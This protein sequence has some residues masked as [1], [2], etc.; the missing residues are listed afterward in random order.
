MIDSDNTSLWKML[1]DIASNMKAHRLADVFRSISFT[2]REIYGPH[3]H[4]RIEINYVKKGRCILHLDN[5]SINFKEGEM[6]I[7][8]SNVNHKFEAGQKGTTLLQLEFL[9]DI[10]ND[11]HFQTE[12]AIPVSLFTTNN[13]VLKI[14]NNIRIMRTVQRI[15][16]ELNVKKPRYE[17]LVVMYYAEL[18][19]LIYRYIDETKLASENNTILSK[20]IHYIQANYKTPITISSLAEALGCTDRYLRHLFRNNLNI[21]PLDFLNQVRI[22]KA[23]ETLRNTDMSIKEVSYECGFN[24]PQYFS[25]KFKEQTGYSP[26]NFLK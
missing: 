12:N 17:Y 7:I 3:K 25:R 5:E 2:P 23:I 22:N 11:V 18:L 1:R 21:A 9:P 13:K 20:A 10:F 6:M 4:T 24:S 26:R 16:S 8:N 19:L 15:V 14:I